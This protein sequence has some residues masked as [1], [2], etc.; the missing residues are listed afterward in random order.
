MCGCRMLLVSYPSQT[1]SS[2]MWISLY[3]LLLLASSCESKYGHLLWDQLLGRSHSFIG[4]SSREHCQMFR[5]MR[6]TERNF[7]S[8][9]ARWQCG[10]PFH[11]SRLLI[12][13]YLVNSLGIFCEYTVKYFL[14]VIFLRWKIFIVDLDLVHQTFCYDLASPL[15]KVYGLCTTRYTFV[16]SVTCLL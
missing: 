5:L 14:K 16:L 13:Y 15:I 8:W 2:W 9:W 12:K 4:M 7:R 6:A 3:H 1:E 11:Y 10:R